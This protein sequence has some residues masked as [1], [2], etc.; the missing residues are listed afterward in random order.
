MSDILHTL[1][2]RALSVLLFSPGPFYCFPPKVMTHRA[3]GS[4]FE[5]AYYHFRQNHRNAVNLALHFVCFFVQ[6]FGNFAL[7]AEI[8]RRSG[9]ELVPGVR[10]LS[11]IT[12]AVWITTNALSQAPLRSSVLAGACIVLAYFVAPHITPRVFDAGAFGAFLMALAVSN[13]FSGVVSQRNML[14]TF[15]GLP[16][17]LT[18]AQYAENEYAGFLKHRAREVFIASLCYVV[19]LPLLLRNPLKPLVVTA[20]VA[21]RVAYVA[22]GDTAIFFLS[23]GFMASLLQ[24]V[25]HAIVNEE[26]TLLALERKGDDAKLRF[27]YG[28]VV[29]FPTL[30][31]SAVIDSLTGV[32]PPPRP[33]SLEHD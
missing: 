2:N 20:V 17:L 11:A 1:K 12:A 31:I 19:A 18:A 32:P 7:L 29:Y 9:H 22:A 15:V 28:H 16:A 8:D 4:D 10:T 27:E 5:Q 13:L 3:M 33:A 24:G 25:T 30:A 26:A 14:L 23:Y 21:L 6:I